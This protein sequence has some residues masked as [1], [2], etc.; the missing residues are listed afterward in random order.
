MRLSLPISG[1]AGQ[2]KI[3]SMESAFHPDQLK[4]LLYTVTIVEHG[5]Q[6]FKSGKLS[7]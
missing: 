4:R 2:Q 1:V 6:F 5:D 7:I 3:I